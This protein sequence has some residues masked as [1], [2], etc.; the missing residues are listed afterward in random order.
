MVSE[1]ILLLLGFVRDVLDAYDSWNGKDDV[2]L[3][4]K[5][6]MMVLRVEASDR[7]K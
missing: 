4:F 7:Q 2:P 5:E 1:Y 3:K 6:L